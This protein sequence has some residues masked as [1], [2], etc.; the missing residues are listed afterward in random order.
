MC[1]FALLFSLA[2]FSVN[3]AEWDRP[4]YPQS[5]V[6]ATSYPNDFSGLLT[7]Y[8]AFIGSTTYTSQGDEITVTGVNGW[9]TTTTTDGQAVLMY[10]ISGSLSINSLAGHTG[11]VNQFQLELALTSAFSGI[12]ITLIDAEA[13]GFINVG[14]TLSNNALYLQFL[15]TGQ[16]IDTA[17]RANGVRRI[18]IEITV[19]VYIP[20]SNNSLSVG[21]KL[22]D[23]ITSVTAVNLSAVLDD[24][25]FDNEAPLTSSSQQQIVNEQMEHASNLQQQQQNFQQGLTEDIYENSGTSDIDD[26]G[27]MGS[28]AVGQVNGLQLAD[29]IS[30]GLFD[31]FRLMLVSLF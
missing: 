25:I 20:T 6:Y 10:T 4:S 30:T 5:T 15:R 22:K 28:D 7:V 21:S 12:T 1:A 8:P 14:R 11:Y 29:T 31:V 24:T 17:V 9:T 3:A 26:A 19:G 13:D 27:G 2:S 23:Y 16:K 18:P